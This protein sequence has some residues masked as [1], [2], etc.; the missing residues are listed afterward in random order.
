[1]PVNAA[2]AARAAVTLGAAGTGRLVERGLAISQTQRGHGK[3]ASQAAACGPAWS[4]MSQFD[5]RQA[6]I[7]WWDRIQNALPHVDLFRPRNAALCLECWDFG[8][9]R[10]CLCVLLVRYG[11]DTFV[12]RSCAPLACSRASP[13]PTTATATRVTHTAVG[14]PRGGQHERRATEARICK[15]DRLCEAS[16]ATAR[17]P[18]RAQGRHA[19][20]EGVC[21]EDAGGAGRKV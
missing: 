17:T 4:V 19:R 11:A 20:D 13:V 7:R 8:R 10:Q 15:V 14:P 12:C 3:P 21:A 16:G 2:T 5:S 9:I 1:M 18:S 6:P